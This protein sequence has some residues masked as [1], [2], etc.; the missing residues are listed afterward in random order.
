MFFLEAGC[1]QDASGRGWRGRSQPP[2]GDPTGP[3]VVD[4]GLAISYIRLLF[5]EGT[6]SDVTV[7][8]RR[9]PTCVLLTLIPGGHEGLAGDSCQGLPPGSCLGGSLWKLPQPQTGGSRGLSRPAPPQ[10]HSLCQGR[11]ENRI[12]QG[13]LSSDPPPLCSRPQ[14]HSDRGVGVTCRLPRDTRD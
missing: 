7:S 5:P 13:A 4:G 2:P 14:G 8:L 12:V 6:T 1:G 3:T 11:W 10:P 9:A